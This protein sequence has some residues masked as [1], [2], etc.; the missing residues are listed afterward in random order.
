MAEAVLFNPSGDTTTEGTSK[1]I[2]FTTFGCKTNRFDT[3]TAIAGIDPEKV[4]IVSDQEPADVYIVNTCT[5]TMAAESEV[6][7]AIRRHKKKNPSC[8]I[9]LMGCMVNTRHESEQM[10]PHVDYVHDSLKQSDNASTAIAQALNDYRILSKNTFVSDFKNRSR[11]EINIQDGCN[12]KCS[13]CIIPKARGFAK[14]RSFEEVQQ[15]ILIAAEHYPEIVLTGIHLG[16]YG[17]D[18]EEQ[19]NLPSLFRW[20]ENEKSIHRVRIS[21]FEPMKL[22]DE[23]IEIIGNS[24]K[25]CPHLHIPLQSGSDRILNLMR[26]TYTTKHYAKKI[27]KLRKFKPDICLGTDIISGFPSETDED[28]LQQ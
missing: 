14:S 18:F 9:M 25:I 23:I 13:Y 7:K 12:A 1:K 15:Q 3:L 28:H 17:K 26:R 2:A 16:M 11:A 4:K 6:H 22:A 8:K 19:K 10:F 5:V 27:E 20:I 24:K 21:S